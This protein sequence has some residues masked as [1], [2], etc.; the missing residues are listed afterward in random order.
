MSCSRILEI[1]VNHIQWYEPYVTNKVILSI[2]LETKIKFT[3]YPGFSLQIFH[4][5]VNFLSPLLLKGVLKNYTFWSWVFVNNFKCHWAFVLS[6]LFS[7]AG[8]VSSWRVA[9]SGG[10]LW[11]QLNCY[12]IPHWC[13]FG[14]THTNEQERVITFRKPWILSMN[15]GV[16]LP[17][18]SICTDLQKTI[19]VWFFASGFIANCCSNST[20]VARN[21]VWKN[22]LCTLFISC[23]V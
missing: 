20:P 18:L 7:Y 22:R 16:L 11:F 12:V 15:G 8:W 9:I 5:L 19:A 21:D 17:G 4:M 23:Y 6:L 2:V 13:C 1:W 3:I 10:S 14:Y